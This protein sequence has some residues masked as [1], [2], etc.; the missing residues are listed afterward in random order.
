[1]SDKSMFEE[2]GGEPLLRA[3]ID[4]FVDRIFDDLMIGFFFRNADRARIKAKEYEFAAAH[5]G[6][7]VEYT[8]RDITE[9]HAAHP[10]MG[11]QFLRRKRILEEVLEEF[12]VPKA[13]RDSWMAHTDSLRSQVTGD[14][15]GECDGVK[16]KARVD[17]HRR[18]RVERLK[19]RKDPSS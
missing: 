14:A 5:L 8:G 11:G 7:D 3:I 12:A 18:A 1:M 15:S 4:R 16:A 17:D 19:G 10:I 2:L 13:I 9:A 6:A